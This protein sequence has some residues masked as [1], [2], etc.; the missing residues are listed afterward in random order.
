MMP[1]M[2][3]K[4]QPSAAPACQ[5][6]AVENVTNL[7]FGVTTSPPISFQWQYLAPKCQLQLSQYQGA[8]GHH[9]ML[10]PVHVDWTPS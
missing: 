3:A 9:T 2:S 10:A 5:A 8:F 7:R 4:L 6:S 1:T